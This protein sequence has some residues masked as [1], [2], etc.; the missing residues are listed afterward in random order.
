MFETLKKLIEYVIFPPGIIIIGFLALG[1]SAR[2][3]KFA[4]AGA[5]FF[6]AALYL[7]STGPVKNA[8]ISPLENTYYKPADVKMLKADAIAV[9]G[10]GAYNGQTLDGDSLNRLIA[11]F[12]LYRKLHIPVIISGGYSTF[13]A[14]TAKIAEKILLKMG[15]GRS[16]IITDDKSNDT[17]QNVSA[18]EAICKK[19]GFAKIILVTSAYHMKRAVFLF[20]GTGLDI[21]PYPTDF[22]SDSRYNLYSFLPGM[23]NLA[24]S[25]DALHEYLGY[26]YY[27]LKG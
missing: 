10:A 18:L 11:G 9:L 16:D 4:L 23:D 24:V 6:S 25:A 5:L 7:L 8:L 13:T 3:I 19:R 20:K 15:V 12:L 2:K 17:E 21:I 1:V 14:S 22:K 26:V 27:K